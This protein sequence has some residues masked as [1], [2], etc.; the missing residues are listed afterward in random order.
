[1]ALTSHFT[2]SDAHPGPRGPGVGGSESHG[3]G[4]GMGVQLDDGTCYGLE[5]QPPIATSH[6]WGSSVAL[7]VD[8]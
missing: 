5:G 1:M 4:M 2:A 7:I 6:C 3:D 8:H